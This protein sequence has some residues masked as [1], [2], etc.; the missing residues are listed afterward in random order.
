MS[1]DI[2]RIR[3]HYKND[4]FATENGIVS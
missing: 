1:I 3:S 4:R 2:E